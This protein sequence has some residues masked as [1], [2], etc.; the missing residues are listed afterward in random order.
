MPKVVLAHG[1][2]LPT[3]SPDGQPNAAGQALFDPVWALV[4]PVAG[5]WFP[6]QALDLAQRA[7]PALLP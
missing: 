4:D 7:N 2:T 1:T 5:A 3:L 6:Q